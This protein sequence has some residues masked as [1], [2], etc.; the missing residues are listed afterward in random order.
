MAMTKENYE[1]AWHA[2]MDFEAYD[3]L[4]AALLAEGKS[5]GNEQSES[6]TAYSTLNQQRMHRILKTYQP[7]ETAVSTLRTYSGQIGW[8]T[9]TEGWCG[10]AAQIA[11]VVSKLAK[12][13]GIPS[14]FVLRDRHPELM[15]QHLTNGA[16]AIPMVLMMHLTTFEVL[17]QFG[18]RPSEAQRMV[19]DFKRQAEPKPPYSEFVKQVQLWYARDKQRGIER[20]LLEATRKSLKMVVE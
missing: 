7:D 15:D 17:G 20:E 10:D 3:A 11:P 1:E 16:R 9:I 4:I 18:P 6:L 13:S 19:M 12:A 14:R 2:A 8:L 5:T